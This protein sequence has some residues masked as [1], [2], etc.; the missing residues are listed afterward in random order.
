MEKFKCLSSDDEVNKMSISGVHAME[1]CLTVK[2]NELP[3]VT[4]VNLKILC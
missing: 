4:W 2:R 1:I 3:T